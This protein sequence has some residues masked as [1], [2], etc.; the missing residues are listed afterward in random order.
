MDHLQRIKSLEQT[1][2]QLNSVIENL[3]AGEMVLSA[4]LAALRRMVTDSLAQL[5]FRTPD[6]TTLQAAIR[7]MEREACHNQLAAV[8]DNDPRLA[9]VLK[10]MIDQVLAD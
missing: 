6:Q 8:A 3:S 10:T 4:R 5:G 1:V 7:T 9:A 2:I